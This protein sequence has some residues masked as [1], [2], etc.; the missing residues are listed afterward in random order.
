[1]EI[2]LKWQKELPL[3]YD[4]ID[5]AYDLDLDTISELPG[6]YIF[7]RRYDRL[8]EALYVGK[9]NNLR[10]RIK[11]QLNN[12]R[13][14]THVWNAKNGRRIV[15]SGEF[16]AKQRQT[17][18]VC[19]PIVEKAL[20]RYFISEGHDL[21]NIHGRKLRQHIISSTGTHKAR[22]FPNQIQVEVA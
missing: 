4:S 10:K 20:I 17:H 14:L 5:D 9:A 18:E 11:T 21:V 1:M 12:Y 16:K 13:L 22:D 7:G 2:E 19:V 3:K 15:M 6:V 8:F